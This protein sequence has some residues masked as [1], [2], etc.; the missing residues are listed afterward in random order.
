M[1]DSDYLPIPQRVQA[2]D[3][4]I[5]LARIW[6]ADGNQVVTL[7][8]QVWNDPAYW[9]LMLVDLA[10]HVAAVYEPLGHDR[11]ATLKRIRSA[12]DAEWSNPTD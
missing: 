4:K 12:F 2:A 6:L 9:G 11:E 10:R 3:R 1:Q 8:T 7:S 5:E